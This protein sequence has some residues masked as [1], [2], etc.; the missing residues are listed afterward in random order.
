M[1]IYEFILALCGVG[2]LVLVLV[3]AYK[4]IKWYYR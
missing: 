4:L 2:V 3:G 1:G